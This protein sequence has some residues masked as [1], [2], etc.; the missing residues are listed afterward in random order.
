[1]PLPCAMLCKTLKQQCWKSMVY[2]GRSSYCCAE[3]R[4]AIVV[5]TSSYSPRSRIRFALT[6]VLTTPPIPN[7][8]IMRHILATL[9]PGQS[10]PTFRA[11]AFQ[12]TPFPIGRLYRSNPHRCN[13][14]L[15]SCMPA[16]MRNWATL[17]LE[18]CFSM[19]S[20]TGR[21]G[22]SKGGRLKDAA[23]V[24]ESRKAKSA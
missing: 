5:E 16:G 12:S 14:V 22:A 24:R 11:L 10:L 15:K 21:I 13:G 2:A 18:T 7:A 9:L 17:A 3:L 8:G 4:V 6:L 1:M 19:P 23:M 20:L